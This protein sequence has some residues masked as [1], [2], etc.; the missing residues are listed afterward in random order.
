MSKFSLEE[1]YE[2]W[3]NETGN[4][5]EIGSDRDCLGLIQIRS[6]SKVSY[7]CQS[8]MTFEP[9]IIDLLI[10]SLTKIK[11]NLIAKNKDA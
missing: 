11:N 2:I 4:H 7:E 6:Y 3:D 1:V 8:H 9:E 5:Y 10:E